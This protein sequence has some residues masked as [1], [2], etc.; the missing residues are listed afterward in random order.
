MRVESR[1]RLSDDSHRGDHCCETRDSELDWDYEP[2]AA[3][4]SVESLT[5]DG[6]PHAARQ[7]WS[8]TGASRRP[9]RGRSN[10]RTPT[11]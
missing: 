5:E 10:A 11:H 3:G 7:G 2:H 9:G 1:G 6:T 8:R 4:V